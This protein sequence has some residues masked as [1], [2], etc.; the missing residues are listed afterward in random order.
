MKKALLGLA[1][2][3]SAC[4][5]LPA[6]WT[7]SR[8]APVTQV[9]VWGRVWTVSQPQDK[10]GFF[11]AVRDNN[12][13]NPYGPPARLRTHQAIRAFHA[14]TGC[15]AVYATMYQNI[16]GEVFSQLDCPAAN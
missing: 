10:P 7:V 5:D 15:R 11:R 2:M 14:A 13:L 1:L 3:L 16:S 12:N 4:T 6:D 8:A 9:T